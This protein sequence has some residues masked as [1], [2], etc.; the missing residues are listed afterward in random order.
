MVRIVTDSSAYL[1]SN[2]VK[3]YGIRVVPLHVLF[4]RTS[5]RDGV[6]LSTAEFYRK[7]RESRAFPTTTQ[8]SA[9]E[10]RKA[11]ADLVSAGH[12]VISIHISSKLSG[13][14]SSAQTAAAMF[15]HATVTVVDTPWVSLA[16]EMVVLEAARAACRGESHTQVLTRVQD[17]M[18]RL[19]LLFAVDT[20]E[21]LKRG[22][23]IGG[24]AALLGTVLNI[25]PVLHMVDGRIE[26]LDRARTKAAARRRLLQEVE[27]RVKPGSSLH[28]GVL[29]A[30]AEVEAQQVADNL[31]KRWTCL[32]TF[33]AE[34]GPVVGAHVGPGTVGVAFYAEEG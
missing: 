34:I 8:P 27:T 26:V 12:D 33:L 6:D 19:N 5:Y 2:L 15:P 30:G 4:G 9:G 29:H 23:R 11:Y 17:L 18:P 28:L 14:V 1:P 22:G 13:T 21:Y 20:L 3:Q 24:A 31:C 7:L 32:K 25:K 16:L 10:F